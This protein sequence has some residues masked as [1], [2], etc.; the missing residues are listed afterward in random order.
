MKHRNTLLTPSPLTGEGWRGGGWAL[1][2]AARSRKAFGSGAL[3]DDN[4]LA[5]RRLGKRARYP[6]V[7]L[8]GLLPDGDHIRRAAVRS[9]GLVSSLQ[10]E[11][12]GRHV[13]VNDDEQIDVAVE[14]CI[15]TGGRT[16]QDHAAGPE[17]RDNRIEQIE[18]NLGRSG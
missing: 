14:A 8:E 11:P 15:A 3:I 5:A 6:P 9:P 13:V 2:T 16:E 17:I 10:G 1:E 12:L 7:T 4:S 18:R